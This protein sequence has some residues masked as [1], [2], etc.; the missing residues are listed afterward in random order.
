VWEHSARAEMAAT[1]P[2]FQRSVWR[3][4]FG[5]LALLMCSLR[6]DG[7]PAAVG[8]MMIDMVA[9]TAFAFPIRLSRHPLRQVPESTRKAIQRKM[10]MDSPPGHR[11][12]SDPRESPPL[13]P[14]Q[15]RPFRPNDE[16]A[17]SSSLGLRLFLDTADPSAWNELLPTG[18]FH[19]VTCNP[20]LLERAGHACTIE[21]LHLLAAHA[22]SGAPFPVHAAAGSVAAVAPPPLEHA[23]CDEFMCQAWGGT[24]DELVYN[25][26]ALS[27]FD[28]S[29]VVVKVPVTAQGAQVARILVS[30]GVRVCLTAC[31][32]ALQAIVAA[33]VGAEYLAPYCGRMDDEGLD[34]KA[35]CR[36][37]QSIVRG[38]QSGTRILVASIRNVETLTDLA[39][40][41]METFT[42][43]PDVA[44]SL[45]QVRL[46][47]QAAL[48]F[49]QA[50]QR[51]GMPRMA[52]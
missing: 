50:A 12:R 23:G 15:F 17:A 1:V 47:E 38:C 19:G 3:W 8:S 22:L 20:T 34:G 29:R 51:N 16:S 44:R 26:L 5:A 18:I 21:S 45:F 43:S 11:P 33:G 25:G 32:S 52:L 31:Y 39:A 10:H 6:N 28:R 30:E 48:E 24:V 49:E 35:E 27:S 37:M 41:G 13:R 2:P 7:V 40:A 46:T 4:R 14:Q 9:A 36:K 42:I